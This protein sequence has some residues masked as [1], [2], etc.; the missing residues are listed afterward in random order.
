M[1]RYVDADDL[2]GLLA[3]VT[4]DEIA[5]AWHRYHV[6]PGHRDGHPDWWAVELFMG[7]EI[8]QRTALHRQLLL[9]LVEHGSQAALGLVGAGPLENFVSD[10][11]DDLR[12]IEAECKT[13]ARLRTA[14]TG[15][16]SAGY[17]SEATIQRLDAAAG[18][19]LPRPRPTSEWP[20]ELVAVHEAEERLALAATGWEPED[21]GDPELGL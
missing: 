1:Q 17:V 16:W 13:N 6:A 5:H 7:R 18:Q 2:D 21:V 11:E 20:P 3:L 19:P 12:W 8:F 15:V 4:A 9:K 14:L 10:D